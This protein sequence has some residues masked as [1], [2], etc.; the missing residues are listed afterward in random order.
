[1]EIGPGLI[2]WNISI[3]LEALPLARNRRIVQCL[4]CIR[5]I[6]MVKTCEA[7]S[8][9]EKYEISYTVLIRNYKGKG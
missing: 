9:G 3:L 5:V 2:F 1:M 6:R 8:A 4:V 7:C